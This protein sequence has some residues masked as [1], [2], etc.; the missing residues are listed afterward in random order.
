MSDAPSGT[1]TAAAPATAPAETSAPAAAP[2]TSPATS[3]PTSPP[4]APPPPSRPDFI[5]E[6]FWD[7][8][9]G[10]VRVEELA[11]S[12]KEI[13]AKQSLRNDDMRKAVRADM[14]KELFGRRPAAADK[15]VAQAPK[16]LLPEGATFQADVNNP[17][18]KWW[19]ETAFAH[20]LS[21]EDYEKGIGVYIESLGYGL[22]DP[23]AEMKKLGDNAQ[24]RVTRA[25]A[26]SK[27]N[28][29]ESSYK[30][31][32]HLATTAAGVQ[33]VEEMVSLHSGHAQGKGPASFG[34]NVP[35]LESL[36]QK[37]KD[38]R[39]HDPFKRDP[40]YVREI[41][42]GFKRLVAAGGGRKP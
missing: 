29:T 7:G 19:G 12:Y 14:D 8:K 21:Q 26:W 20:G 13:Q 37:M 10:T 6:K 41:E 30:L 17:L 39:Y 33:L 40:S 1:T 27:A 2:A 32:E 28:L 22:P 16:G 23:A 24:E 9:A 25:Q 3:A 34:A 15:Y 5:E 11:K 35:T 18:F 42:D 36:Q 4:A 38:P 31:L